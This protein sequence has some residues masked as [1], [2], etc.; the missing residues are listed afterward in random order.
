M[1]GATGDER[2]NVDG[3]HE[4]RVSDDSD[5]INDKEDGDGG[6]DCEIDG[7]GEIDEN[8]DGDGGCENNAEGDSECTDESGDTIGD[9][10]DEKNVNGILSSLFQYGRL[11]RGHQIPEVGVSSAAEEVVNCDDWSSERDSWE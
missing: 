10:K 9:G 3:G 4:N 8:R 7:V 11:G 6:H 2:R 5:R 1:D